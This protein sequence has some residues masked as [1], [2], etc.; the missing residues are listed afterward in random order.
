M[1]AK[2]P[3]PEEGHNIVIHTSGYEEYMN[4][5]KHQDLPKMYLKIQ[6]VPCSKHTPSLLN[7]PVS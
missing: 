3:R 1:A 7:K 2:I 6:F 5:S 4:S